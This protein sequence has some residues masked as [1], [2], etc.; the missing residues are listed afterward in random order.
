V[1]SLLASAAA[2]ERRAFD[3][4][5]QVQLSTDVE[6]MPVN[7]TTVEWPLCVAEQQGAGVAL[8]EAA[9]HQLRDSG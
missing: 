7:E 8:T 5:L 3:F 6:A 4:D 1:R 2:I 9:N